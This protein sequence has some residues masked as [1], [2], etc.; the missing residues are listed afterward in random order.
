MASRIVDVLPQSWFDPA[1]RD[2]VRDYLRLLPLDPVDKK[3]GF[4]DWARVTGVDVTAEDI[5]IVT[6][7]E[8]GDV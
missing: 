4:L 1:F 8:A 3:Q 5:E 2:A 7:L 6:G